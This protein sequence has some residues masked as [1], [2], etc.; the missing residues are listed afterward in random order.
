MASGLAWVTANSR[1][2]PPERGRKGVRYGY[3]RAGRPLILTETITRRAIARLV[4]FYL[5]LACQPCLI[6]ARLED[7]SWKA[8]PFADGDC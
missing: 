6:V 1:E 5:T 7:N 3:H 8:I 4:R 2:R